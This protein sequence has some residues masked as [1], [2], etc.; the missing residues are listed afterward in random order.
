M[1]SLLHVHAEVARWTRTDCTRSPFLVECLALEQD[2]SD[3]DCCS[4]LGSLHAIEGEGRS[5]AGHV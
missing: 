3:Q 5:P 2:R 1:V 4:H